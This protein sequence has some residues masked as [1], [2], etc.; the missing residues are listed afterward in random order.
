MSRAR[1]R[2][3]LESPVL[4]DATTLLD[5]DVAIQARNNSPALM[6]D[7]HPGPIGRSLSLNSMA[8]SGSKSWTMV[9]NDLA[10]E[11]INVTAGNSVRIYSIS[12][13]A[14]TWM[15]GTVSSFNASTSAMALTIT[16]MAP[17]GGGW[18]GTQRSGTITINTSTDVFTWSAHGLSNGNHVML[19]TSGSLPTGLTAGTVYYVINATTNTFQ[20][21]ASSGGLAIDTSGSQSGTH[22]AYHGWYVDWHAAD[23][24]SE[25]QATAI[26]A[27]PDAG[28]QVGIANRPDTTL[29]LPQPV[30]LYTPQILM[31]YDQAAQPAPLTAALDGTGSSISYG[32]GGANGYCLIQS[33]TTGFNAGA[34][35]SGANLGFAG[36][37]YGAQLHGMWSLASAASYQALEFGWYQDSNNYIMITKS[38]GAPGSPGNYIGRCKNA[39]TE[40]ILDLGTPLRQNNRREFCISM[41]RNS[42]GVL[43]VV[44]Y[45][46]NFNNSLLRRPYRDSIITTNIP[47]G[48]SLKFRFK[49]YGHTDHTTTRDCYITHFM[50]RLLT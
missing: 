28:V 29:F 42:S 5:M 12:D 1:T 3:A 40:S 27:D 37:Y 39:G 50:A 31:R 15:V 20:V 47:T 41:E 16:S 2:A 10:Q 25:G 24:T 34:T 4:Q 30:N 14:N 17:A 8:S 13:S 11:I 18:S 49:F 44:F 23:P 6:L 33:G 32:V 43:G 35:I 21:S 48:A 36:A 19:Q 26:Y 46:G 22:T 38:D 7:I 45:A 9:D